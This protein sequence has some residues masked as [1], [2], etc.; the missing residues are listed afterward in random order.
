MEKQ[1]PIVPTDDLTLTTDLAL[2]RARQGEDVATLAT[3]APEGAPPYHL[4]S[5]E[6]WGLL[7]Q[8]ARRGALVMQ[9]H[10]RE[11]R[12][13]F[14]GPGSMIALCQDV[15]TV[16]LRRPLNLWRFNAADDGAFTAELYTICAALNRE[17]ATFPE[18]V[19]LS[20]QREQ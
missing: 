13:P 18:T 10:A 2:A 5:Q 12:L 7:W 17:L 1:A 15:A 6:D 4:I 11:K 8:I 14:D 3:M 16:H 9:G 20:F 19:R